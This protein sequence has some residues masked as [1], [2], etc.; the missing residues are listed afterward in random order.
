MLDTHQTGKCQWNRD[1]MV[2]ENAD[3]LEV[4]M[5]I[6]LRSFVG[7]AAYSIP[8]CDVANARSVVEC[9]G[10]DKPQYR[11]STWIQSVWA[12]GT[13]ECSQ[14]QHFKGI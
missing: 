9:G 12:R 3:V 5:L 8:I 1:Q 11:L 7:R 10:Y 13:A 2:L 14:E 4:R 6:A